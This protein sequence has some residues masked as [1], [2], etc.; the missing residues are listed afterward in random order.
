M[1]STEKA[2]FEN[3]KRLVFD[4]VSIIEKMI[5]KID[6]AMN[7]SDLHPGQFIIINNRF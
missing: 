2:S 7:I 4:Y 5:L 1:R 3:L 6:I